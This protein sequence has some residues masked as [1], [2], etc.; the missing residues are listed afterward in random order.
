MNKRTVLFGVA[1]ATTFVI[2]AVVGGAAALYRTI[3]PMAA[4]QARTNLV[5]AGKDA[6]VMYRYAAYPVARNALLKYSD[7]AKNF[8][9]ADAAE[10]ER[11]SF[12][13]GLTYGRLAL[14][15]EWAG[16]RSDAAMF[17]RLAKE[18]FDRT[19]QSYDEAQIRAAIERLDRAWDAGLKPGA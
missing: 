10:S 9:S 1:F 12:D 5:I 6:Y 11:T 15:A 18:A 8:V 19:R 2:G 7:E 3:L 13:I 4:M 16:N 17:M 14:A